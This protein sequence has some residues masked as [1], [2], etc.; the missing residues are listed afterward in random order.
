MHLARRGSVASSRRHATRS[1]SLPTTAFS[2]RTWFSSTGVSAGRSSSTS[3]LARHRRPGSSSAMHG[4]TQMGTANPDYPAPRPAASIRSIRNSWT[5]ASRPCGSPAPTSD[6]RTP[7]P[8][9][10]RSWTPG[11]GR[12]ARRG[13][14]LSLS[15][16]DRRIIIVRR[17]L[18]MRESD[19]SRSRTS[20]KRVP[21]AM[22]RCRLSH[23]TTVLKHRLART[24][25]GDR[26]RC[27]KTRGV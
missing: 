11:R 21:M 23:L 16:G 25:S 22:A 5:W 15:L 2:K 4:S 3:G 1:L 20:D 7:A 24:R 19:S 27:S 18:G 9:H 12:P 14:P 10:G 13:R 8:G 26:P 6:S 17:M